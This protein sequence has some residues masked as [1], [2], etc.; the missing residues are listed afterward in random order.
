M[1]E[2]IKMINDKKAFLAERARRNYATRKAEGRQHIKH[3]PIEEQKKAGRPIGTARPKTE[4]KQRGRK[5]IIINDVSEIPQYLNNI[6][7]DE[8]KN[9]FMDI[10]DINK[11]RC[12]DP[13]IECDSREI[14]DILYKLVG[15]LLNNA[16]FHEDGDYENGDIMIKN[17]TNIIYYRMS[18]NNGK[19]IIRYDMGTKKYKILTTNM[20]IPKY[21]K[22]QFKK[23]IEELDKETVNIFKSEQTSQAPENTP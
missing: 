18:F 12:L 2:T 21:N 22:Y 1:D 9:I 15:L 6:D 23:L 13:L 20:N 5:P 8:P 14:R 17:G 4:P 16:N 19:L 7:I 10:P 3:I 11:Y